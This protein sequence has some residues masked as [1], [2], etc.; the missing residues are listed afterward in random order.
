MEAPFH[1]ALTRPVFS[2][3]QEDPMRPRMLLV[4]LVALACTAGAAVVASAGVSHDDGRHPSRSYEVWL[5]D[6]EDKFNAGAGS[7][8]VYDGPRL[9]RGAD[10]AVPETIDLG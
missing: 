2:T 6:Q 1:D 8:Y 5:I 3:L 7:L 10:T 9:A 4:A